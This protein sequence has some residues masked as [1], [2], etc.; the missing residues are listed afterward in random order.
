MESLSSKKETII[1]G[2]R[3]LS[4]LK[5]EIKGIKD[6]VLRNIKNLFEYEKEEENYYNPVRL[7]NF[8]SNDCIEYKSNGDKNRILSVEVYIDK[9]RPSLKDITNDLKKNLTHRKFN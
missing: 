8:W 5:K 9:I 2:I 4:R 1:K 3:N 7:N 6:I